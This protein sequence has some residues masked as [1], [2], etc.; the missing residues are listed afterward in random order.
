MS[1]VGN[2]PISVPKGTEIEIDGYEVTVKGRLGTLSRSFNTDMTISLN[3]DILTVS[4]PSDSRTHRAFHGLTRSLLANMVKG[5]SEGFKKDLDIVGV[6]YRAQES[7]GKVTMQLGYSHPVEVS[8]PEG[9]SLAVEGNNRIVV[10]G[11]DKELV[12]RVSANIR[13][14][15]PP[16]HYKGKGVRYAGEY[17][18]LKAVKSGKVGSRK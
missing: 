7:G 9:I 8:P 16:D 2:Q 6:G 12:G 18:R 10:S 14:A 17:V 11:I 3:E 13:S 5:V 1:R 4:R 15:R